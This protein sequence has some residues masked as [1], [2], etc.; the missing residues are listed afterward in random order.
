MMFLTKYKSFL[1][2]QQICKSPCLFPDDFTEA[3]PKQGILGDCWLLCA[4]NV[5]LKSRYLLDQVH[6]KRQFIIISYI[7]TFSLSTVHCNWAGR[8]K[9]S[10]LISPLLLGW[11]N[12]FTNLSLA[13]KD[14]NEF[15]VRW[16]WSACM[17]ISGDAI[18]TVCVGAE[19]LHRSVSVPVL[20]ERPLDRSLDRWSTALH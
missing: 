20:E 14:V 19:R 5:L 17:I 18:W 1:F 6:I 7:L 9:I 8:S 13:K 16:D 10:V 11:L 12:I 2:A 3:Y 15:K 4:C